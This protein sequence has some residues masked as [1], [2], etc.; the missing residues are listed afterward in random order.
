MGPNK[1]Q[2]SIQ[3]N[4]LNSPGSLLLAEECNGSNITLGSNSAHVYEDGFGGSLR[5]FDE[6]Q[7]RPFR[8]RVI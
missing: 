4:A 7:L 2:I 8:E 5:V 1:P 6:L 3:L